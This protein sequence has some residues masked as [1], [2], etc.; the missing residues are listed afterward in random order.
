MT[1]PIFGT[2]P[3]FEAFRQAQMAFEQAVDIYTTAL[4]VEIRRR[5]RLWY[6]TAAT[7]AT[8][9]EQ[10]ELDEPFVVSI[11]G[12]MD[13]DGNFLDDNDEF[14]ESIDGLLEELYVLTHAEPSDDLPYDLESKEQS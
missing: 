4:G 13:A 11:M 1:N 8:S 10:H 3:E 12:V 9:Y 14:G 6:P 5:T 7:V 2:G